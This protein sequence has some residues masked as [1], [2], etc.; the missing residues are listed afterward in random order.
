MYLPTMT[1]LLPGVSGRPIFAPGADGRFT[2]RTFDYSVASQKEKGVGPI[3]EG[4][5][6]INPAELWE[7]AWY[8]F[9]DPTDAWGNYRIT[10]HPYPGTEVYGRGGFFIHGGAEPGS[11][12]CIDLT[13]A[14]NDFVKFLKEAV[15]EKA[16]CFIDLNVHYGD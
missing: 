13:S 9:W 1:V 8:K 15:G 4:K 6:W 14:M 7:N 16:N 2:R 10:I 12:G 3:P 5:Y 11:A